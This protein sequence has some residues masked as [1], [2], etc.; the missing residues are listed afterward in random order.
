M[1]IPMKYFRNILSCYTQII[2]N[3][4]VI[5][6][7]VTC[8]YARIVHCLYPL[9]QSSYNCPVHPPS[10]EHPVCAWP[11]PA[12]KRTK[13]CQY[14]VRMGVVILRA[15]LGIIARSAGGKGNGKLRS[16]S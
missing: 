6:I 7:I 11:L 13:R 3:K 4:F 12:E 1:L 10:T 15:A 2:S 8:P 16:P 5:I 9:R 14:P